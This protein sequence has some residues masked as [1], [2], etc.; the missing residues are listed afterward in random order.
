MRRADAANTGAVAAQAPGS[1]A[2]QWSYGTG[3]TVQSAPAVTGGTAYLGGRDGSA[4]AVDA[5]SGDR[6]WRTQVGGSVVTSPAVAGGRVFLTGTGGVVRAL[7]AETG[8]ERWAVQLDRGVRASPTVVDGTVYVGGDDGRVRAL[9]AETGEK[10]WA[11]RVDGGVTGAPAVVDGT[12]YAATVEGTAVA[13][14]AESGT[15]RWESNL[16]RAVETPPVVTDGVVC[17]AS[18]SDVL[19]ALD[20]ASGTRRWE[21]DV[22]TTKPVPVVATAGT[23]FVGS[24]DSSVYSLDPSTGSKRY[25]F[26]PGVEAHAI[27]GFRDAFCVATGRRVRLVGAES[28]RVRWSV[29]VSGG[30]SPS[31]SVTGR[32]V[33]LVSDDGSVVRLAPES[34]STPTQKRDTT[35]TDGRTPS[36]GG[37]TTTVVGGRTPSPTGTA[38]PGGETQDGGAGTALPSYT[39]SALAS[40][41]GLAGIAVLVAYLR[42]RGSDDDTSVD[43]AGGAGLADESA[44]P[45]TSTA[46]TDSEPTPSPVPEAGRGSGGLTEELRGAEDDIEEGVAAFVDGERVVARVRFRQAVNRFE[47]ALERVEGDDDLGVEVTA[48][49]AGTPTDLGSV[50]G[51][52]PEAVGALR[53][54]GYDDLDDAS[55]ASV[56]ELV[57]AAGIDEETA[58]LVVVAAIGTRD[59]PRRFETVADVEARRDAAAL[60]RRLCSRGR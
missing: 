56:D 11:T 50:P 24:A 27:A 14:D 18:A 42:R 20:A 2:E 30:T 45:T 38:V 32:G 13:L 3:T 39:G 28:A 1:A 33:Y 16:F 19:F 7:G 25:E 9:G 8:E 58:A 31:L 34:Q 21:Y 43:G 5:R 41:G 47:D 37:T 4:H 46:P 54:N 10:R 49:A 12:V 36:N 55:A 52:D 48:S 53:A 51:L 26:N 44:A 35:T 29:N 60:G 59:A 40:I 57:E 15:V 23:L 6:I 22:S 17:L